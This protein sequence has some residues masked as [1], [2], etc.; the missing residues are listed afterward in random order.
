MSRNP[1]LFSIALCVTLVGCTAETRTSA[2]QRPAAAQVSPAGLEVVPLEINNGRSAHR[3]SVEIARSPDEQSRGLMF[4]ERLGDNEGMIFPF[5]PPTPATF[6]MKNTVIA[7]DMLFIRPD[8]TIARIAVNTV[9]YSLDPVAAGEPV[10]A[11]L[12]LR[13]GRS[14]ELGIKAGDRVSW[15]GAPAS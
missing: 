1:L 11:V 2:T 7:L 12:E 4:R 13:G 8:G 9:P 5:E 6:W 14:V 15:P 3:F 10:A